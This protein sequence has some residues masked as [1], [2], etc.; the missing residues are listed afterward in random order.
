MKS[1]IRKRLNAM[2]RDCFCLRTAFRCSVMF[3]FCVVLCSFALGISSKPRFTSFDAPGAGTCAGCGTFPLFITPQG[4]ISGYDVDNTG[5]SHG[6]LRGLNGNIVIYDAPGGSMGTQVWSMT[7]GGLFTGAYVD[8]SGN[9]H[10]FVASTRGYFVSFDPPDS[11]FTFST[12]INP[13]GETAGYYF[14]ADGFVHTFVRTAAG[15]I[16]TFDAI[17]SAAETFPAGA[18]GLNQSGVLTGGVNTTGEQ[19]WV[20]TPDGTITVFNVP[21]AADTDSSCINAEGAITGTSDDAAGA[22]HG[23]VRATD[24]TFT[25]FD[26][27][28]AGTRQFQGTYPNGINAGGLVNGYYLDSGFGIHGFVRYPGGAIT[29]FDAPGAGIGSGQGTVPVTPNSG[30]R[31]A[32]RYSDSNDVSHGFLAIFP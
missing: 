28:G 22:V 7:P 16:T 2:T 24:G 1:Q 21:G 20:R 17:P 32:G 30:G 13:Q 31:I 12:N 8:A 19:G 6:F 18:C 23:Y 10:G 14:D 4:L 26:V 9:V 27:P 11:V 29:I 5:A 3:A 15:T 25:T